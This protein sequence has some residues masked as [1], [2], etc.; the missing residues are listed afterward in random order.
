MGLFV[1]LIMI[2]VDTIRLR[3]VAMTTGRWEEGWMT[4]TGVFHMHLKVQSHSPG[5]A[6]SAE[7]TLDAMASTLQNQFHI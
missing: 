1:S 3:A 4:V 6:M 7:C 5:G 2:G